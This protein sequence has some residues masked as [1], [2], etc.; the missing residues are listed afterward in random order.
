MPIYKDKRGNLLGVGDTVTGWFGAPW[1]RQQPILLTFRIVKEY[2][3]LWCKGIESDIEDDYLSNIHQLLE[4][5]IEVAD[6]Q[7]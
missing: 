4:K 6:A 1:D 3:K 2:G 7:I 5:K